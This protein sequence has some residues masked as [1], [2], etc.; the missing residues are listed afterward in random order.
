MPSEV[1]HRRIGEITEADAIGDPSWLRET[2]AESDCIAL[3]PTVMLAPRWPCTPPGTV[4][5]EG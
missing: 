4:P 2:L 1:V 3:E 5:R